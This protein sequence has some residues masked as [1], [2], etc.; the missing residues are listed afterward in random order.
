MNSTITYLPTTIKP[1]SL[2]A[3]TWSYVTTPYAL[4]E[5][6]CKLRSGEQNCS[7]S[8]KDVDTIFSSG[9]TFENCLAYPLISSAL[10]VTNA[11]ASEPAIEVYGVIPNDVD[12]SR[13]ILS[14]IS[15][16][17]LGY[18][19]ILPGCILDAELRCSGDTYSGCSQALLETNS[20]GI[21]PLDASNP[22]QSS[23]YECINSL[24]EYVA[25]VSQPSADVGG[26]G[27]SLK[28]GCQRQC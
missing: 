17:F 18:V 20:T 26:I 25:S 28:S 5:D 23:S 27:V 15:N 14:T 7:K 8:C 19:R 24:C 22:I 6:G 12:G 3:A 16:C 21:F 4:R 11:S 10:G 9:A 13:A 1:L 2:Q